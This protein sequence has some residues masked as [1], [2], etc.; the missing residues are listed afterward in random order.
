VVKSTGVRYVGHVAHVEE[1][2]NSR[3]PCV[4]KD[5]SEELCVADKL[6]LE[7]G[8]GEI[9]ARHEFVGWIYVIKNRAQWPDFVKVR[10][11]LQLT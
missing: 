11:K 5:H 7:T 6:I 1:M 3:N 8:L 2:R 10:T 9:R 4:G